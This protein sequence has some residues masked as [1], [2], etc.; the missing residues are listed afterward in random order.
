M[1]IEQFT[2]VLVGPANCLGHVIGIGTGR[3]E[4]PGRAFALLVGQLHCLGRFKACHLRGQCRTIA[5]A[6]VEQQTFE[7]G[8][9]LN[10]H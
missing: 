5:P 9:D 7:V 8:R 2:A 1:R 4:Q 6:E 10:I 3:T